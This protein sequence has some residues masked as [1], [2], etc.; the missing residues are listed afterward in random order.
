M[1][2]AKLT[3]V[4]FAVMKAHSPSCG[5]GIIYD[6]TFLGTKCPGDGVTAELLLKNGI[7]VFTEKELDKL[8]L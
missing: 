5:R 8:P 4:D 6:G 7:E 1:E 3:N 2:I